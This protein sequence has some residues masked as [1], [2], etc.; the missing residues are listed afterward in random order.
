VG[1]NFAASPNGKP[2]EIE[3][4]GEGDGDEMPEFPR[5][6]RADSDPM[7]LRSAEE[8]S[9]CPGD[10]APLPDRPR[11][12]DA[13]ADADEG[14]DLSDTNQSSTGGE[15]IVAPGERRGPSETSAQ[16]R[17]A[18]ELA[19]PAAPF[20]SGLSTS[21]RTALGVG[22]TPFEADASSWPALVYGT[23][24][25]R[26]SVLVALLLL[27]SLSQI[28]LEHFEHLIRHHLVVP[29]FLTM[30][31]GAGGNAG[32]QATVRV[33]TAFV[34]G[35]ISARDFWLV[36]RTEVAI[37]F[38]NAVLLAAFGFVR[39]YY[40]YDDGDKL[41][42]SAVAITLS[43]FCIVLV[44]AVLGVLLPFAADR[45]QFDREHSA[46]AIQVL[47]DIT[48]VFLTCVICTALIPESEHQAANG[49][50][51]GVA[52]GGDA[53]ASTAPP[54]PQPTLP[55]AE[56][57]AGGRTVRS[58]L[59]STGSRGTGSAGASVSSGFRAAVGSRGVVTPAPRKRR[60]RHDTTAPDDGSDSAR[61]EEW[62]Y[63]GG[64]IPQ[65]ASRRRS[66]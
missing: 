6:G 21:A 29:L 59:S 34:T 41:V 63:G 60:G 2:C 31:V 37:G 55:S 8:I 32:N 52:D 18:H 61:F 14:A 58:S 36:F 11:P 51:I 40:L 50:V 26:T 17:V 30:L 53:T 62:G 35:E 24:R 66:P 16:V 49:E 45:L 23:I 38:V 25:N 27:Q 20:S 12:R 33:I 39:V 3:T 48:G 7:L 15:Q 28:V 43:L 5:R 4:D 10:A 47:M 54:A 22:A 19:S 9:C 57:P 44:S 13:D 42:V 64:D 1:R 56:V 65:P 46:P